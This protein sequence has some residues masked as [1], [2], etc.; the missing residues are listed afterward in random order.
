MDLSFFF[1]FGGIPPTF[2]VVDE[3]PAVM[4]PESK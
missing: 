4:M 3:F 2:E 1:C